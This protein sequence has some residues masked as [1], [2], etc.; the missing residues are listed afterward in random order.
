MKK[1]YTALCAMAITT[2]AFAE[3]QQVPN[4][5]F[6]EAW[7]DC[8]PWTST[9]NKTKFGT[10]PASWTIANVY[11]KPFSF[12]DG[13]TKVGEQVAGHESEKAVSLYNSPNSV[14]K[15]QIV[16]GYITLGTPWNTSVMGNENDGG[17]FDGIEFTERPTAISFWYKRSH[18]VCPEDAKDNVKATYNAD[19]QATVVAYLWKGTYTQVSVPA[20]IAMSGTP[21]SVD[22]VNR[23]RNIL[24]METIKGG[25]VTYTDGAECIA[26][27]NYAI[28]GD[29]EDW[30]YLEIPFEYLSDAT[31]EKLNV[32]F[33]A[34]DYFS[35]T[36][37]RDNTLTIDD[38]K[39]VYATP[40]EP[41]ERVT[42]TG[43]LNIDLRVAMDS[44]DAVMDMPNQKLYITPTGEGKCTLSILG[45]K[46][47]EGDEAMNLGDI[48]VP[49]IAVT[50][51]DGVKEYNGTGTVKLLGD[52]IVANAVITGTEDAEGNISLLINVSWSQ[53]NDIKVTFNGKKDP[54]A[55]I[56]SIDADENAPAEYYDLRGIRHNADTLAPGIY[57]KRQGTKTTKV[58]VR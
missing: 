7:G 45:L 8:I 23:D 47:G 55:S 26:K 13:S 36:P 52:A 12:I 32:I 2:M 10:T 18:G 49:N 17:S 40:E 27:I 19:E 14:V 5:G 31:P 54:L 53:P 48:V 34:G 41:G 16:P 28:K 38:V 21:E 1:F 15:T 43:T 50:E 37:G 20:A 6:E 9:G 25:N 46:L 35:T 22:M 3:G 58:V 29:A 30:T 24:S 4:G 33:S 42:Y 51:N 56:G 44:D 39:L 57:I 11:Y